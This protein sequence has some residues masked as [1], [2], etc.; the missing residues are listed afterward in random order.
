MSI[1][2][3]SAVLWKERELLELLVFKLEVERL[4]LTS[5]KTRWIQR[6]SDEIERVTDRLGTLGLARSVEVGAV[7]LEWG[8][9]QDATLRELVAAAPD[10]IWPEILESHLNGLLDLTNQIRELRDANEQ[11]LRAAS[12]STQETLA[13][14]ITSATTYNAQGNAASRAAT[15]R[16]VDKDI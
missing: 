2:E 6:A 1:H 14:T 9:S 3:L 13:G 7:S 15:S 16:L 4:L 11:L 12:R 10:G 8:T 5:G